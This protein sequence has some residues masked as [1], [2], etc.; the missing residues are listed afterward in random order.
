MPIHLY[1]IVPL[2]DF[3]S[4]KVL[5]GA[6]NKETAEVKTSFLEISLTALLPGCRWAG[7]G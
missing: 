1:C 2:N 7:G 6:L 3:F 5:A 4:V